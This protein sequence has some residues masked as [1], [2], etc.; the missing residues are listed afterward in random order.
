M[1]TER[2]RT[3]YSKVAG[4][5]LSAWQYHVV[6]ISANTII[7]FNDDEDELPFGILQNDPAS[8]QLAEVCVGGITK[9]MVASALL[10]GAPVSADVLGKAQTAEAT[11][12]VFGRMMEPT[13]ADTEIGTALVSFSAPM[14]KA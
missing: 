1:A 3:I 12:Y 14:I 10:A 9:I 5:D 8:G 11:S 4:E 6:K 13:T 7:A 2:S